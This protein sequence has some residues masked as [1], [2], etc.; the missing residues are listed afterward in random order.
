MPKSGTHL[1]SNVVQILGYHNVSS[2]RGTLQRIAYG[3]GIGFPKNL[4]Y[5]HISKNIKL[6]LYNRLGI[7]NQ[8]S[9]IPIGVISPMH[10]PVKLVAQWLSKIPP[11]HFII[12]H[13]PYSEGFEEVLIRQNFKHMLIVRDPRDV[14]LSFL[15]YS[16]KPGHWLRP[17]LLSL[18]EDE[19][20]VF[21][22]KGGYTPKSNIC[23]MGIIDAFRSVMRWRYS[24]NFLMVRFEDLVGTKGG[25]TYDVQYRTIRAICNHLEVDGS[26]EVIA[27]VCKQ[28]FDARSPTFRKGQIGMWKT[29][30]TE[31][32]LEIFN[33]YGSDLLGKLQYT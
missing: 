10:V 22:I 8:S 5:Q 12:G 30:F 29:E 15:H 23:I 32:Q 13:V 16:L 7:M 14:L 27:R 26:E 3:K 31:R 19:R 25:G 18:A 4:C 6:R 9:K 17:D 33:E 2:H 11:G 28:A 24:Q 21:A 1:L 20:V